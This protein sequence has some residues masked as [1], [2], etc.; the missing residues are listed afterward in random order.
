[1][2]GLGTVLDEGEAWI[3]DGARRGI[4]HHARGVVAVGLEVARIRVAVVRDPFDEVGIVGVPVAVRHGVG[5]RSGRA[6]LAPLVDHA[7]VHEVFRI[8][9]ACGLLRRRVGVRVLVVDVLHRAVLGR[10]QARQTVAHQ[11]DMLAVRGR[12]RIRIQHGLGFGKAV[13]HVRAGP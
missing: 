2:V 3:G 5:A 6:R 10:E 9:L 7:E 4:L 11:D 8:D 13:L 1:M 12:I